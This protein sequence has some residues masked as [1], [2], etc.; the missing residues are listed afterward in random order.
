MPLETKNSETTARQK[1]LADEAC[2]ASASDTQE[3][4]PYLEPRPAGPAGLSARTEPS[5]EP[6]PDG[7]AWDRGNR[8]WRPRISLREADQA[9]VWFIVR[10]ERAPFASII[11]EIFQLG[12]RA[13]I[14]QLK[15]RGKL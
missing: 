6:L 8:P 14:E 10:A 2:L 13:K 15:E 7:K 5:V 12:V 3:C 11:R 4:V 9:W 1:K